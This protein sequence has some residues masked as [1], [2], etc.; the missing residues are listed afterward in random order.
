[1]KQCSPKSRWGNGIA[2]SIYCAM[3]TEA[4]LSAASKNVKGEDLSGC[5]VANIVKMI[6][7][8]GSTLAYIIESLGYVPAE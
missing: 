1:M 5:F 8:E 7:A 6:A 3:P 2:A 4:S